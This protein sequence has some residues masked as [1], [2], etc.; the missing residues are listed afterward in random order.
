MK[1]C[2][3]KNKIIIK[4]ISLSFHSPRENCPQHLNTHGFIR[5]VS[6]VIQISST[7]FQQ[8]LNCGGNVCSTTYHSC[9]K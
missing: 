7:L 1:L 8:G 4:K 2:P 5:T 9:M 6:T 3:K